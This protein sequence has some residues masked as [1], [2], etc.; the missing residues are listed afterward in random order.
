MG[1]HA[2]AHTGLFRPHACHTHFRLL[3]FYWRYGTVC[4]WV[5]ASSLPAELGVAATAVK[6]IVMADSY[7]HSVHE[8]ALRT[9]Y[10]DSYRGSIACNDGPMIGQTTA[11]ANH[12]GNPASDHFYSFEVITAGRLTFDSCG[13]DYD[14]WLR[15]H[16]SAHQEVAS[17]DDCG[18]CGTRTVLNTAVLQPGSYTLL[19]EGYK[20]FSGM[21]TVTMR[22]IAQGE[23]VKHVERVILRGPINSRNALPHP[24]PH[25]HPHPLPIC[26]SHS[27]S[28]QHW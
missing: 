6:A 9:R 10:G 12:L 16:D 5:H 25:P 2:H 13:S 24:H 8:R 21:Y 7:R 14:T 26:H 11:A 15:V 27:H 20:Q 18:P 28:Q 23:P 1:A 19:I 17:C 3:S 22:G 4:F